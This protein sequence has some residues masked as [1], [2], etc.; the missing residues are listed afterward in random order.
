MHFP[1]WYFLYQIITNSTNRIRFGIKVQI[2]KIELLHFPPCQRR[3]STCECQWPGTIQIRWLLLDGQQPSDH[4]DAIWSIHSFHQTNVAASA[5]DDNIWTFRNHV[6]FFAFCWHHL[7]IH[8]K[9]LGWKFWIGSAN[10]SMEKQCWN[11]HPPEEKLPTHYISSSD[12]R[13]SSQE[14]VPSSNRLLRLSS[15]L[16]SCLL[17][18]GGDYRTGFR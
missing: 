16:D 4:T 7:D 12:K 6:S 14:S 5:H 8:V 11:E 18:I 15:V 2:S 3:N 1:V 9:N 13:S 10:V 17:L